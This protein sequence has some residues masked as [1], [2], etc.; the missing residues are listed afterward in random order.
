MN[1]EMLDFVAT[2]SVIAGVC[3]SALVWALALAK[4]IDHCDWP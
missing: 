1:D 3:T 4:M 2:G